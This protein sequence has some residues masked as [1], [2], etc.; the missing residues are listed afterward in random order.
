MAFPLSEL[1]LDLIPPRFPPLGHSLRSSPTE[2]LESRL[3][4]L[5]GL[6]HLSDVFPPFHFS[7]PF[8]LSSLKWVFW[9]HSPLTQRPKTK[10]QE[11]SL[12]TSPQVLLYHCYG[13]SSQEERDKENR[14]DCFLGLNTKNAKE[15][16]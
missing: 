5:G 10:L 9:R 6:L 11:Q 7:L 4:F 2:W 15:N 3:S 8:R 16:G 1:L 13:H 14:T 12:V